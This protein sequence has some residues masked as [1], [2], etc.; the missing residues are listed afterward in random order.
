VRPPLVP[1]DLSLPYARD[2]AAAT[3]VRACIA[4]G[5]N[6]LDRRPASE[7]AKRWR[8][9]RELETVVRAA[10]S[11]A[12]IA[13]ASALATAAYA[14]LSALVPVSAGI[15]LLGRGLGLKFNGAASII[16]PSIAVP[17]AG[18]VSELSGFPVQQA[19]TGPGTTLTPSKLGVLASLTSEMMRSSNA[20]QLVKQVLIEA[21]GPAIDAALF[22]NA[23]AGPGPP[24]LLHGVTA[25][26]PAAAGEKS[27]VLVDDIQSLATAI[28]PVAGNGNIVLIASSDA[29]VALSLRLPQS[30]P[31]PV[32][33][34]ASLAPRTVI[35]VAANGIVSAVEG[36]PQIDASQETTIHEEQNAAPIVGPGGTVAYP[37]RSMFQTDSISLRL[38][39]PLSWSLRAPNAIA[40]MSGV[41]W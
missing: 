17:T 33:T 12:A 22:S 15:D 20:E 7:H 37:V 6:R 26:P 35:A 29:S 19:T 5:L 13:N 23:A 27:Q 41:N 25:L 34:S 16:V 1:E 31:W 3:F 30:V 28:A 11:P 36:T 10:T 9:D 21:C 2:A 38:R 40:F 4:I 39:W 32:L 24:G 18:F 14:F 8:E